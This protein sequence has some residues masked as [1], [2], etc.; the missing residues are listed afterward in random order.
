MDKVSLSRR[1]VLGLSGAVVTG[2]PR[3]AY[4]QAEKPVRLIVIT[5]PGAITDTSARLIAEGLRLRL[6]R[7]VVV[8]NRTGAG[9]NIATDYVAKST[10]DGDTLL[11]TSNN[12]TTNPFLYRR[13][14]YN[15]ERDLV[16]V[17]HVVN[18]ALV[19]AANPGL[20]AA[21]IADLLRL[22]GSAPGT[23]TY[24]TGGNGSPG[25]LAVELFRL[26]S[27]IK[28]Q[29]VPY[30]GAAAAMTDAVTGQVQLA[31]GSL[32][33][34]LSFIAEGKL[35]G[36]A[37]TDQAR[38]ASA[39][40]LPTMVEAGVVGYDY[41]GWI[42]LMAPR[43]TPAAVIETLNAAVNAVTTTAA[44]R[45]SVESQGGEVVQASADGFL[46]MLRRDFVR[47]RDLISRGGIHME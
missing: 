14:P 31:A 13:L 30:R 10:P 11:V 17:A 26:K 43:G 42:G 40:S 38:S 34:A 46:E 2:V 6:G 16:P 4:S 39:P 29:H 32:S 41:T 5:P 24:G 12:H 3:L 28:L 21:T 25:H 35:I 18:F 36:L 27:G 22:T 1:A 45:N 9:G 7:P 47:D 8:E 33:S 19:L 15:A 23:I 44:F 37:V 20:R